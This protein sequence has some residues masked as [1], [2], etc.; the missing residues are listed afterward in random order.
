[1]GK[2]K[3]TEFIDNATISGVTDG[4]CHTLLRFMQVQGFAKFREKQ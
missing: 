4:T 1:V 3:K 2:Q